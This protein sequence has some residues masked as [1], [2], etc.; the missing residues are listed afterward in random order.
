MKTVHK[1]IFGDS[2][3][4]KEVPDGSVELVVTSPPY[5]MIEMWDSIF[6]KQN[7]AISSAL[8]DCEGDRA[9]ELMHCELDK[10]W[11]EVY[12]VLKEGGFACINIGDATRSVGGEFKLYSNHARILQ[13][14]LKLG[15]SVLPE[16]L[17]RKQTNAPNKFMG[18]GMLPAGAYVT[19]EHEYILVLRKGGKRQFR[20]AADRL[21]RLRSA[22]FWEERNLWFSDVWG[23]LKGARQNEVAKNIRERS[24]AYPFELAYRLINMFSVKED[25]VLDP[26]LGTG[27]TMVASMVSGR[28]SLG[29]ELDANFKEQIFL[30]CE[31]IVE[32]ANQ[33]IESR[34]LKHLSFVQ[35]RVRTNGALGHFNR[36]YGFPVMTSQETEI[37]FDELS[38]LS[39]LADCVFE[40]E[41]KENPSLGFQGRLNG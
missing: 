30:R 34:L 11:S 22:F 3:W 24:G 21:R 18:S 32:F 6:S 17:W 10:V 7:P 40:V 29:V 8:C 38:K 14:C 27:T 33:L 36:V 16:V 2:R 20:G 39:V 37:V 9:F 35:D 41:Y 5:P 13:C 26:F 31:G 25:T 28:N 19:L 1:V 12:R 4:M 23:D 15:F